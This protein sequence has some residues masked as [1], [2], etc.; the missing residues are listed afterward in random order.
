MSAKG[1]AIAALMVCASLLGDDGAPGFPTVS[2]RYSPSVRATRLPLSPHGAA[3]LRNELAAV[4][5]SKLPKNPQPNLSTDLE[6]FYAS[7]GGSLAWLEQGAPTPAACQIIEELKHADK[8][9][10][11]ARDYDSPLW[12][13]RVAFF[14]SSNSNSEA[15]QVQFDVVLTVNTMRFLS[16]LHLG[17]V[18][19]HALQFDI[20]GEKSFDLSDF[21]R[22]KVIYA[23]DVHTV[24]ESVEPQFLAYRRT[25]RALDTYLELAR[26]E[27]AEPLPLSNAI[28]RAGEPYAAVPIL[29]R[30]LQLLGDLDP[31]QQ[32]DYNNI[33]T[34]PL[35]SAVARFQRRHGLTAN[36]YL[37]RRTLVELNTPLRHRILQLQLTL[38]R[39]RWLPHT[40]SSP[41]IVVNIPEFRLYA[42]NEDHHVALAM[43]VMTGHAFRHE[44]PVFMSAIQSVTFRPYWNVPLTIQRNELLPQIPKNPN[45][46]LENSYEIVDARDQRE[47]DSGDEQERAAKLQSGEWQLRQ[48]P[49][50]RNSLGLVKF[51]LPNPYDIYLHGTP[52]QELFAQS[53]RDFSH[54]CI[55]LEDP[56]GLAVWVL[57]SNAGWDQDHVRAA[58]E[59]NVTL[60][61]NLKESIPAWILYGTAVVQEDGEL[62]FLAD[63]YGHDAALERVLEQQYP[64]ANN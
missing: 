35:A 11:R 16:H 34:T 25:L 56:V 55:R 62:H 32:Y 64:N 61:V 42:I 21:M 53:R 22:S 18:N 20:N 30:R 29:A 28:V 49:G 40:F 52:A 45:Y 51:E 50:P 2:A 23:N 1:I 48:R 63:I 19:P 5:S 54:G 15:E 24:V 39:W 6:R 13:S 27:T 17:R 60:R 38:E 31:K 26:T 57:R 37:D 8:K 47:V 10:L 41:P 44:T 36:G 46:L 4:E 58:M 14:T 3:L 9:G 7:L 12:D 59:G 43:N 33:Y